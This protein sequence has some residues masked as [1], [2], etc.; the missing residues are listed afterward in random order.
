M[1]VDNP[2]LVKDV[3]LLIL[4][5]LLLNVTQI[6]MSGFFCHVILGRTNIKSMRQ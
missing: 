4:P 2:M 6:M 1:V 3:C 5:L